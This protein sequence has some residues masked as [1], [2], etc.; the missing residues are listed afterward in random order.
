MRVFVVVIL[1][2]HIFHATDQ[3]GSDSHHQMYVCMHVRLYVYWHYRPQA[4]IATYVCMR[5]TRQYQD[6]NGVKTPTEAH[7]ICSS[8]YNIKGDSREDEKYLI[9]PY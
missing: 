7:V 6:I 8:K 5:H 1:N 3:R 4:V 2:T 9:F